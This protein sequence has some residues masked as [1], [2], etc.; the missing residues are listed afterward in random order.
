MKGLWKH[1]GKKKIKGALA[2]SIISI[3]R[4]AT[5]TGTVFVKW[6]RGGHTGTT[7]KSLVNEH[8]EAQW[9]EEFKSPVTMFQDSKTKEFDVKAIHFS[10][11][12][13][14]QNKRTAVTVGKVK[15]NVT[16]SINEPNPVIKEFYISIQNPSKHKHKPILLVCY[17]LVLDI[18]IDQMEPLLFIPFVQE[19]IAQIE[20]GRTKSTKPIVSEEEYSSFTDNTSIATDS[21]VDSTDEIDR[22]TEM[23]FKVNFFKK[24][25]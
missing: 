13:N 9:N 7:K 5:Q 12:L 2:F 22:Q 16:K 4:L 18:K 6:K 17:R 8:G 20:K 14:R 3:S 25:K 15:I 24:K 19:K 11:K 23:E 10:I 21:E 1:K